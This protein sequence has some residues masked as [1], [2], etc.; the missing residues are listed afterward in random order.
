MKGIALLSSFLLI[1]IFAPFLTSYTPDQIFSDMDLKP[2]M[3]LEEG[4]GDH[5]LGTDDLGR[6][7]WTRIIFGARVSLG[8][9]LLIVLVSLSIGSVL[10]LLA[11]FFG[12]WLDRSVM[13]FVDV[14]MSM[15][16]LLLAMVV[17]AVLGPGLSNALWAVSIVSLPAYIRIVRASVMNEK[18]KDY[19]QASRAFGAG[20][21]H[22]ILRSIAPNC[23]APLIV[24]ST[25]GFSDAVLSMAALGFLGLGAQP[26]TPEWGVMLGDSRAYMETSWWL[27]MWPGLSLLVVVLTFNLVGD[28]LRDRLDPRLKNL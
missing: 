8:L 28:G 14:I 10:G 26:P 7:L 22:L 19:V 20:N 5:W 17:V 6:D 23:L 1:A 18:A 21:F 9:G 11:G 4:S 25:L 15:P 24:Q 12:G 3:W 13:R 2:P 27:V 16:S